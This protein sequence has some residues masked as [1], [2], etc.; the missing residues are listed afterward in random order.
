MTAIAL[1]TMD[2]QIT[3]VS[4]W[5]RKSSSFSARGVRAPGR[6]YLTPASETWGG[7]VARRASPHHETAQETAQDPQL[8]SIQG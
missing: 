3:H 2:L 8:L 4:S 6:G 1:V 7:F 5:N